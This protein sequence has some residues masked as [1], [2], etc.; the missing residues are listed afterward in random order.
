M[1]ANENIIRGRDSKKLGGTTV[2]LLILSCNP[3]RC[4]HDPC[5]DCGAAKE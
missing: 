2:S 4:V 1:W 5:S 3:V